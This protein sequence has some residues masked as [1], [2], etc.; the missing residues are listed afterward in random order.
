MS[1]LFL[2]IIVTIMALGMSN[3]ILYGGLRLFKE[4]S[5]KIKLKILNAFSI[6]IILVLLFGNVDEDLTPIGIIIGTIITGYGGYKLFTKNN[7]SDNNS[8]FFDNYPNDFKIITEED[9]KKKK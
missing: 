5:K 4:I 6:P 1:N 3:L 2:S 8:G 9:L 7:N